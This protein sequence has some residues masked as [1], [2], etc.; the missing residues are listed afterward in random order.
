DGKLSLAADLMGI[1]P[2]TSRYLFAA[3]HKLTLSSPSIQYQVRVSYFEVYNGRVY[4]LL[5]KNDNKSNNKLHS[6]SIRGDNQGNINVTGAV[7]I[8]VHNSL[9][10]ENI[11]M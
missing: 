4:D 6:L 1:I 3:I 9:E 7:E 8:P 5:R 10:L 11:L 2:R